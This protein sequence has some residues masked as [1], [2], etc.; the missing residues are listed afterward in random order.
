V[1]TAV[2]PDLGDWPAAAA[3][4]LLFPLHGHLERLLAAGTVTP[5]RELADTITR[6]RWAG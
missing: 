5:L 6:Y 1:A 4:A 2:S 3:P